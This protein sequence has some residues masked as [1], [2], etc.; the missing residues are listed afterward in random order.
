MVD[1]GRVVFRV[2]IDRASVDRAISDLERRLAGVGDIDLKIDSPNINAILGNIEQRLDDVK[3]AEIKIDT[4]QAETKINQFEES[5]DKLAASNADDA[6]GRVEQQIEQTGDAA[7]RASGPSGRLDA[8]L[9]GLA[10]GAAVAILD[11]LV[12]V[13]GALTSKVTEFVAASIQANR[14]LRATENAL[15]IVLGS[16]KAAAESLDFLRNVSEQTGQSFEALQGE[17]AGLSAAA[18]EA[19]VPQKEINDLFAET[20][21]VL[22][23]FGKDSTSTG[24]AFNALTQIASKG[25][26]SMEELRQQLGEQLPVAFGATARGLGITTAELNELV[27]TGDFTVDQFIPAFTQGL[28]EIEGAAPAAQQA[29]SALENEILAFQ[30][31]LGASLE[32]LETA[33]SETFAAIFSNVDPS[34]LDPLTQAGERL[35]DS[36][37]D[38]PELAE[39][40][41]QAL[42]S[43]A[44]T[45]ST[46]F[47]EILDR[48]STALSNPQNVAAFADGIEDAG[49]LL[50]DLAIAG[51]TA[52]EVLTL[53]FGGTI[54]PGIDASISGVEAFTQALEGVKPTAEVVG[55]ALSLIAQALARLTNLGGLASA[56]VNSISQA[57]PGLQATVSLFRAASGAS[58]E[59]EGI[60]P[61]EINAIAQIDTS[62]VETYRQ[63]SEE[64]AD[65]DERASRRAAAERVKA[66][67]DAVKAFKQSNEEAISAIEQ[68]Q[69]DRIAGI[70]ENQAAG[71]I[72][73]DQ[74][75]TQI[76]EIETDAIRERLALREQEIAQIKALE[77]QG[78]LSAEEAAKKISDAKQ[79]A[80]ELT[81]QG[82]EQEIAAQERAKQATLDR[83]SSESQL[84]RLR[85]EQVNLQSD[86]AG[87]ALQNQS[88]LLDAQVSL[89]QSRLGLSRQTL[90]AKL[91]EAT[92]AEDIVGI[93]EVRD[94]LLL[95][96]RRSISTEFSARRQQLQIQQQIN[97]LDA[98]RQLR[99]GQIA[100]AE[101]Q[102]AV[103]RARADGAGAEQVQALEQIA[104]LREQESQALASQARNAQNILALQFE[105]LD[106]DQSIAEQ[107]AIQERREQAIQAFR[108]QQKDLADEQLKS[109]KELTSATEQRARA[110]EGIVSAL[111]GL[112]DIS[113]EDALGDLDQLEENLRTARRSGALGGEDAR[114]LQS[115]INQAQ[116]AAR[117][118]FEVDEA[119]DFARRNADN[120]F[121]GGILDAVGLGGVSSFLDS[122]QEVAIADAQI[123]QLT[124]KLT[125]VKDAIEQ[126]PEQI[127]TGIQSLTVS[128][129]DPI[130]DAATVAAQV[131]RQRRNARGIG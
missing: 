18:A 53:L 64:V 28:K 43:A 116:R 9:S 109:E 1:A 10:G 54:Q 29:I 113:A 56:S 55:E 81:V 2:G 52:L 90:D 112:E 105:Q 60:D 100:Q 49:E 50:A 72:T 71:N 37:A 33:Y 39:R 17:Y 108:E 62:F 14:Q 103:E 82:L 78:A 75:D 4:A 25:V 93:E 59:F 16:Q 44:D 8:I 86:L 61:P 119:F 26:V 84:N 126:L 104:R 87:T 115:V 111:S 51:V 57:I 77:Q 122:A 68:S 129:P 128:T 73:A 38:N 79:A 19:G 27:A 42:A 36:L 67:E 34:A 114:D 83:L 110:A 32:P 107:R 117:G 91:A 131:G 123:T 40:F 3:T 88:S 99:L 21:R 31:N 11:R 22:A 58:E 48:I 63:A 7:Q 101:A 127:P 46:A 98:D 65:N 5:L 66:N 130:V 89:E 69:T 95:N 106:A 15:S 92:A 80:S 85:A 124:D 20:S 13:F 125:E 12:D 102:I 97:Q 70:R 120:Q 23:I 30:Q 76:A 45:G 94:Q 24:L 41:G 121:T 47:A 96:Q 35:R 118:G 6:L 74:A